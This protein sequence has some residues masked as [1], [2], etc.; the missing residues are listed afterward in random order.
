MI[1]VLIVDDHAVVRDATA[2]LLGLQ[3]DMT[4]V[5]QA[6]SVAEASRL[7]GEV[8]VA[9]VDL[10]LPDGS[11]TEVVA[12]LRHHN[13]G[14]VAIILTG[15]TDLLE[16]ARAIEAGASAVMLKT[17]SFEN[18]LTA[19]RRAAAGEPIQDPHELVGLLQLAARHRARDAQMQLQLAQLTPRERDLLQALAAGLSDKEI[20]DRLFLSVRT[21]QGHM[22]NVLDKL[23]VDSRLQALVVALRHG[24]I[25]IE[26]V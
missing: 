20:A 10:Q 16:H 22:A 26:D 24:V 14:T 8:D 11:G 25:S 9:L 5:G 6:G 18:L 15:S 7:E 2:Y 23:G 19:I 13:P 3:P 17:T 21:V 12:H 4:V 1:R